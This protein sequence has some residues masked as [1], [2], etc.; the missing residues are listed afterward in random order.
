MKMTGT[1]KPKESGLKGTEIVMSDND[2]VVTLAFVKHPFS[3]S[4]SALC[5]LTFVTTHEVG[6]VVGPI[7][8]MS[9]SRVHEVT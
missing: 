6:T 9:T 5:H 3:A 4:A 1:S 7:L 2:N 8:Q